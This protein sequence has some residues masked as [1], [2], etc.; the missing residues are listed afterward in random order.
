M[1][2]N[3]G[4]QHMQLVN[5]RKFACEEFL[6]RKQGA[7]AFRLQKCHE[8]VSLGPHQKGSPITA[9]EKR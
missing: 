9:K 2:K 1:V 7:K 5:R 3:S 4:C 8:S 6:E